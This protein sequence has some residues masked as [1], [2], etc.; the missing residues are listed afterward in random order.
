MP[1][2][3]MAPPNVSAS[4]GMRRPSGNGRVRVRSMRASTS[5]SQYWFSASVPPAASTV[6]IARCSNRVQSGAPVRPT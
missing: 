1:S 5:R 2:A 3:V 6:P 4:S